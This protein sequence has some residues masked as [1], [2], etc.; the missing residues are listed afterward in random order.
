[1][2]FE[3]G[4]RPRGE[5]VWV[6]KGCRSTIETLN[7]PDEMEEDE[8]GKHENMLIRGLLCGLSEVVG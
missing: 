1:M 3:S 5:K 7:L 4:E 2:S 6:V 8:R